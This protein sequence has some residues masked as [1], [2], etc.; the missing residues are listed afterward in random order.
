LVVLDPKDLPVIM[1]KMGQ[2][3]AKARA[4]IGDFHKMLESA[5]LAEAQR[6]IQHALGGFYEEQAIAPPTA[7]EMP[8]KSKTAPD[9]INS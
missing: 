8:S 2:L 6:D 4:V 1:R 5:S 9:F 3:T 7:H